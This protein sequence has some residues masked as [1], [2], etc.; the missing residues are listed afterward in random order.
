[1]LSSGIKEKRRKELRTISETLGTILNITTFE[2]QGSQKEEQKKK[3]YEKILEEI[4]SRMWKRKQ[5]PNPKS[6]D[7]PIE[8][9]PKEKYTKTHIKLTKIK[10]KEKM[11]KVARKKQKK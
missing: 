1:M 7:I 2:L 6:S 10:H 3:G 11:L 5:P 9:K 4:T 8:D